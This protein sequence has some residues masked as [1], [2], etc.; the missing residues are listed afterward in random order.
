MRTDDLLDLLARHVEPVPRDAVR[1]R[2]ARA[3]ATGLPI[4]FLLMLVFVA[5]TAWRALRICATG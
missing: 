5:P 4:S 3:L 1:R 2:F